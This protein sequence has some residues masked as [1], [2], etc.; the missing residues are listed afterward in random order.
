MCPKQTTEIETPRP[1]F[2]L[3]AECEY[4][5]ADC[6]DSGIKFVTGG[7]TPCQCAASESYWRGA[8]EMA[9]IPKAFRNATL[10][11]YKPRN[12]G[13]AAAFRGAKSLVKLLGEKRLDCQ[14]MTGM[15]LHG[16]TGCGKS[17]LA[18]AIANT[19]IRQGCSVEWQ[20]V[21]EL[22]YSLISSMRDDGHGP[23]QIIKQLDRRWLLVLDDIGAEKASEFAVGAI[24][25]ILNKRVEGGRPLIATSNFDPAQ[26]GD[27]IGERNASRLT[28]LCIAACLPGKDQRA[29]DGATA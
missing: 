16:G 29:T 11:T 21:P 23:E 20:N 24:Y 18:A 2:D 12:K 8:A 17:H 5:C 13:Q 15:L 3:D 28:G 25:Q 7:V 4:T 27:R 14:S 10:R 26:L 1:P 19:M 6:R 9:G 22:Y